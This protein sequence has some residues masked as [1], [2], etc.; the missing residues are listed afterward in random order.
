MPGLP[1]HIHVV[2]IAPP[3]VERCHDAQVSP[4]TPSPYAQEVLTT[5][6]SIGRG[7]TDVPLLDETI[8]ANLERTV[9][10]FGDR[11]ALAGEAVSYE[12]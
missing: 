9:G 10:C 5:Q 7:P 8:G 2:G 11:E 12:L 6:P 4:G 1:L 3:P